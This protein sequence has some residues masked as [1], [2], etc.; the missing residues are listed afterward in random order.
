MDCKSCHTDNAVE[1]LTDSTLVCLT[2]GLSTDSLETS[3]FNANLEIEQFHSPSNVKISI[4][5][6][7]ADRF[8]LGNEISLNAMDFY[9][10][11]R[12]LC[13]QMPVRNNILQAYALMLACYKKD[14]YVDSDQIAHFFQTSAQQ[15]YHSTKKLNLPTKY[16]INIKPLYSDLNSILNNISF[17]NY[18]EKK[19]LIT[20]VLDNISTNDKSLQSNL[21]A[22]Y[23]KYANKEVVN[24]DLMPS[25]YKKLS[26]SKNS[27]NK[28]SE[29]LYNNE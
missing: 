12:K 15:I 5:L 13:N 19:F 20:N 28:C 23:H 27:V 29:F 18:K 9:H 10:N 1:L 11:L 16:C 4:F 7:C 8:H 2:C 3:E 26:I 6:D 24:S 21:L 22:C 17:K 14:F 25:L